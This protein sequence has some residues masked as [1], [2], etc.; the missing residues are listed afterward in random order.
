MFEKAILEH[1]RKEEI[2]NVPAPRGAKQRMRG[3]PAS[4]GKSPNS[5]ARRRVVLTSG[6]STATERA[7]G[8][9]PARAAHSTVLQRRGHRNESTN[10][11]A[12]KLDNRR[13]CSAD[14]RSE[15]LLRTRDFNSQE[16]YSGNVFITHLSAT[17]IYYQKIM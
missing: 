7:V 2:E 14:E 3:D 12:V 15:S 10:G 4:E 8:A 13:G 6:S 17:S 1:K 16:L 5:D 9:K 11:S